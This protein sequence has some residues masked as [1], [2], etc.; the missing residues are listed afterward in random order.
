MPIFSTDN[1]QKWEGG[2][3]C[4]KSDYRLDGW[5]PGQLPFEYNPHLKPVFLHMIGIEKLIFCKMVQ[6]SKG[7]IVEQSFN[8]KEDPS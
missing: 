5:S 1:E 6:S 3:I 7:T 4:L 2:K 8:G